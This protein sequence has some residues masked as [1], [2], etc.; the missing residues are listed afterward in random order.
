MCVKN[1]VK[2][3]LSLTVLFLFAGILV[4][5]AAHAAVGD[6]LEVSGANASL[7]ADPAETSTEL[8]RAAIGDQMVEMDRRGSWVFVSLKRTGA[9]GWMKTSVTREAVRKSV[10]SKH[11]VKKAVKN[12]ALSKRAP[13]AVGLKTLP[14]VAAPASNAP[15]LARTLSLK[16]IGLTTGILFEG[17]N[18]VHAQTF[19]FPAPLDSMISHGAFR[20]MFRASPNLLPLANVRVSI[21]DVPQKQINLPADGS[22]HALDVR[23]PS[24]AFKGSL[25]KVTVTSILPV[26]DN[27]CFDGRLS[28]I[29]LHVLPESA[30]SISYQPVEKSIRDAWRMLPQDVTISLSAGRLSKEQFASTLALMALLVDADKT[31]RITRLPEVGDIVIAPRASL[32]PVVAQ[33]VGANKSLDGASN[34]VLAKFAN[35]SAIVLLDPYDIQPMYLLDDTWK[36]L[37]AA[38]RYRVFRP[39]NIH[40]HV[41]M[42]GAGDDSGFFALPLAKLGMDISTRALSKETNWHTV[43]NPFALP[44]G[45]QPEMLNLNIVAPVR[46]D[47]DPTYELYVFLNDVLVKAARLENHGM[48]QHFTVNLPEEYQRQFNDIRI[49]VQHDVVEGNCEG[50]MPHDYVQITPDSTLV[51]KSSEI[52]AP[53]AFSDLAKYFLPGF[54]TYVEDSYLDKPEQILHLMSRLSADFPLIIDHTRLHF[55]AAGDVLAPEGP[56]VGVGHFTLSDDIVAPVRFDRGRVK[57][58]APS[59]ESYFDVDQLSKITIAQIARSATAYGLWI[60]PSDAED[61]SKIERLELSEDDVAFIDSHGVAKT[62]DSSEP[63]LAEVYYPD[64]EDWFD[65]LGKYKFWLMV[66]LWFLMTMVVVYLYRMSRINKLA[67]EDDDAMYQ[68]DEDQM[69]GGHA[70]HLHEDQMQGGHAAHLHEDHTIHPS[71]DL[72]HL[73]EKR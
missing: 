57:I 36:M 43:I 72:D 51:V 6:R 40:S 12:K 28:D 18:G 8:V 71:S 73:D 20:L 65:V 68:A 10:K 23:L 37:A 5:P 45:T 62:L 17:A 63:T 53:K 15:Y 7:Y 66:L 55:M 24:S 29:F 30:L 67:R 49:V 25:V 39:D 11:H 22:M 41:E 1:N 48:K 70:A 27:R 69:Q 47:N 21:N 58:T 26:S 33:G 34:L 56:F 50:V 52:D 3:V 44:M 64:V 59:G 42:Q 19:Y 2:R 60:A 31:V 9:Q 13:I 46:W 4:S 16:D 32:D 54:D 14:E 35:R 38:E 61:L